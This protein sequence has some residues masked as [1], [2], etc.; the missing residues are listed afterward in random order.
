MKTYSLTIGGSII[1][2]TAIDSIRVTTKIIGA[3]SLVCKL[4]NNDNLS[5][6][7]GD[8]LTL[9]IDGTNIFTGRIMKKRRD[10]R[11]I[12]ETTAYDQI[13]YLTK[14]RETYVYENKT[15]SDVL[16]MIA[17]DFGL[18]VGQIADTGY[19]IPYRVEDIQSLIDIVYTALDLT[20]INTGQLFILHDVGGQLTL[21]NIRDMRLQKIIS[22]EE[23]LIDYDYTT[24]ISNHTYNK[25]KLVRNNEET[26]RRDVFIE[27][28]GGNMAR[29]GHLQRH[30]KVG[31]TLSESEVINLT[32]RKLALLNRVQRKLKLDELYAEAKIRAGNSLMVNIPYL[33]DIHL[34]HWLVVERCTHEISNSK[35]TMTLDLTGDF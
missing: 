31:D 4:K 34:S 20:V 25:I 16:R 22:A 21:K 24:D 13:F 6:H 23:T 17:G 35:H 14:N 8:S 15:A 3:G 2:H 7:E 32:A 19:V 18:S 10:K 12:I 27:L 1:E 26:A 30:E 5:F 28:D 29:W 11:Q 9:D 33:G